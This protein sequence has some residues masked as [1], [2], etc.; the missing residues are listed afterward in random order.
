M[1]AVLILAHTAPEHV[2][3]LSKL[4]QQYFEIYIHFDKKM[5][6]SEEYKQKMDMMG[7]HYFQEISVNWGGWSIAG[8]AEFLMQEAMKNPKITHIHII[9][10]QDW[11]VMN[12]KDIYDFYEDNPNL[13]IQCCPAKGVEKSGQ[14]I[15]LWQKYYYNFDKIN[16]RTTFG[17][18]YH[19]LLM[20]VQTLI[21]VDKFKK[22]KIDM[23]LYQGANWMDL[24][25]DAVEYVLEYFHSH[26]NVQK[27]FKTGFCP[28]EFWVQTILYNSMFRERI[29]SNHHRYILW[30]ERYNS[31]PAILDKND[32]SNIILGEHHFCRKVVPKISDD[33]I[34]EINERVGNLEL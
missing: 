29:V 34:I 17:K 22:L 28:D 23:E 31:Y 2:I 15:I 10:G 5:P 14:P 12:I 25:R 6:L 3:R 24:P 16:R 32:V 13:Y 19:R 27:L 26:P 4:M 8:A 18:I 33:F 9:S 30:E 1:Q 11:P 7:I 20:A 21:G